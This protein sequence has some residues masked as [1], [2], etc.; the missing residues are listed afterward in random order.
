MPLSNVSLTPQLVQ[1]VRDAVDIVAIASEHTRLRKAGRRYQGLCPLHKEKT[2]SFSVDPVQGLFYCFGCGAGGDAIKLH[3]LT[4]SDDFP[5]AIEALAQRYGIPLPSRAVRAGGPPE[6]DLEGALQAA[7]RFFAEQLRK[8]A[9]A[10]RY[11][12]GRRVPTELVERFGLGYAPDSWQALTDALR[13][14][15]ALADLEAAG[16]VGRSERDRERL[17]DRFRNRLMFPIHNPSGRLVGFGGRTLG[18]DKAKYINTVETERFHKGHLLYGLYQARQEIREERRAVLVEGYFDV[19][20]TVASGRA[21]AVAGM[22]TALTQEQARL[23]ARYADEVVVAYDGDRAGETAFERALPILLAE[24]MGVLRARFGEGHDPDSLRLAS[25][26]AAVA[27]A[28]DA[29]EDGVVL[30]LRRAIP[31]PT[32]SARLKATQAAAVVAL[33][34][35]IRDPLMRHEYARRAAEM[36]GVSEKEFSSRL[37]ELKGW[38]GVA[39][40]AGPAAGGTGAAAAARPRLVRSLEEQVLANLL[41][42]ATDEAAA[43]PGGRFPALPP[44]AELPPAEVFLDAECR[45]I[46]RSFCTLYAEGGGQAVDARAVLARVASQQATVDRMAQ[47]LLEEPFD[48]GKSGLSESLDKLVRRWRQQRLRELLSE[49]AEAQR[50]GDQA[51]LARLLDEKTSMSQSLH[52]G[53]RSG[54]GPG[55]A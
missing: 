34:E 47:I 25:G 44:P 11:L 52:R 53:P 29:A 39:E 9:A 33:L 43:Q 22:G 40:Q 30:Q 1:A 21:G 27:A 2:P 7:A 54:E 32:A 3:M 26:E 49:I 17:Y 5:A 14:R 19:I 41:Q 13:S 28:I 36:L 8:S 4:T 35:P 10:Q 15:V 55:P 50:Q 6:R 48:P 16:L 51:R 24:G 37:K 12:A 31:A 20:A 23:L 46:Y 45:N 38:R 42:G 18:D